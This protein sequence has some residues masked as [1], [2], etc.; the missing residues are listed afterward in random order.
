MSLRTTNPIES[1]F[2]TVKLRTKSTRGAGSAKTAT[3]MAFKLLQECE[4]KWRKIR[5]WQEIENLLAGVEYK[6]GVMVPSQ[7]SNREAAVS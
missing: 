6:D 4:K 7:E 2:A 1:S 5:G 3:T